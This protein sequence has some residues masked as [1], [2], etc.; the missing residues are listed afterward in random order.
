MVALFPSQLQKSPVA[1]RSFRAEHRP[2][3]VQLLSPSEAAVVRTHRLRLVC[4]RA[5]IAD[6][7]PLAHIFQGSPSAVFDSTDLIFSQNVGADTAYTVPDSLTEGLYA[8]RVIV[9][10]ETGLKRASQRR[11]FRVNEFSILAMLRSLLGHR[12]PTVRWN[13]YWW[14]MERKAASYIVSLTPSQQ[15]ARFEVVLAES[16]RVGS[17]EFPDLLE[18]ETRYRLQVGVVGE[19]DT[20]WA[21]PDS[22]VFYVSEEEV[23]IRD[24]YTFPN[25]FNP[26]AAGTRRPIPMYVRPGGRLVSMIA[27]SAVAE[28]AYGQWANPAGPALAKYIQI[29]YSH[30]F[31]AADTYA[32]PFRSKKEKRDIFG[33][34]HSG[35]VVVPPFKLLGIR[36]GSGVYLA[37]HG[38]SDIE[39]RDEQGNLTGHFDTSDYMMM[40][41]AAFPSFLSDRLAVGV[42]FAYLS[43][44][45]G[46]R[47]QLERFQHK[48]WWSLRRHFKPACGVGC[49]QCPQSSERPW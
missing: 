33:S 9:E 15:T 42:S 36:V 5:N 18:Q 23:R 27:V 14:T 1:Y 26:R 40:G 16:L 38:F 32:Y 6:S 21:F 43:E 10:A 25:P 44:S 24:F 47:G 48:P 17:R 49:T 29:A 7:T 11:R 2:G 45:A 4:G 13:P 22:L 12:D 8:W 19:L 20:M 35:G 34:Y 41:T 46:N 31:V 37:T 28:D 30:H 3:P 39:E